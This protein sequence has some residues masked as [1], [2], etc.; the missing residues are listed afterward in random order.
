VAISATA[1]SAPAE[2]ASEAMPALTAA[3]EPAAPT[4]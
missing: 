2:A 3:S 4:R 1:A